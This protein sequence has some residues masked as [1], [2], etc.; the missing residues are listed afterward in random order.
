MICNEE[1]LSISDSMEFLLRVLSL[2]D[3]YAN[4][5]NLHDFFHE[6]SLRASQSL[7]IPCQKQPEI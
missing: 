5:H 2:P 3:E 4:V 6:L 7:A 1:Y